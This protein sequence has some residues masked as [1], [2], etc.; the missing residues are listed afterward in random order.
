PGAMRLATLIVGAI[1]FALFVD[2]VAKRFRFPVEVE[3]MGGGILD[4]VER[5]T[6]HQPLYVAPSASFIPF[7]YP[8]LYFW[9][10]AAVAKAMPVMTACRLVSLASTLVTAGLLYVVSRRLGAGR[11]WAT[12]GVALFFAAYSFCG[13]WYDLE[14]CDSL[15][16]ALTAASL[17]IVTARRDAWL[18]AIGGAVMGLAFFA[19]QPALIV[20]VGGSAGLVAARDWRRA[21]AFGG[22]GVAVIALGTMLLNEASGGWFS[23]YVF[24]VPSRHGIRPELF[25]LFLVV[26]ASQAFALFAA[27]AAL[28][29][30]AL[31][32]AG[33]C[34]RGRVRVPE[35]DLVFFTGV[36]LGA[37][38][39]SALGRWHLGGWRNVLLFWSTFACVAFAVGASRLEAFARGRGM[40]TPMAAIL[41]GAAVL[42]MAR[43]GYTPDE[44]APDAGRVRDARV[45]SETV[46]HLETLG[47]VIV[48]GRGHV[49]S[50][51]H[52]HI[53]ALMDILRGGFAIPADLASGL[54]S[55]RYAA[56]VID[57]FG[58][59]SMEAMLNGRRSD[60]FDLVTASY[61]V[62]QRLDDRER[63]PIVGWI[64]HPS[65]ILRPRRRPLVGQTTLAL[66]RRQ[67]IEIGIAEARMRAVQ[68]GARPAD[69]GWDI[70][71]LAEQTDVGARPEDGRP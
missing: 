55:R 39:A 36:L 44:A 43:F 46:T 21:A 50:P 51:R 3:W 66:E 8:P 35:G 65:W 16:L 41:C 12:T 13:Y 45:V 47:E 23:T 32:A 31:A 58:E 20:L 64:A 22:V 67:R 49:T 7:I 9:V 26:D 10:C 62:A 63:P 71:E 68:A 48:S 17:A 59:L 5:V 6:H 56:Y 27:T 18:A 1:F 34:W 33:R 29:A 28:S 15:S 57:E 60:L 19:K 4:E 69:A 42:Q 24:T 61:F 70:E 37:F 54:R 30:T 2:V 11:F 38:A 53:A 25:T 40:A 14:R 52:F